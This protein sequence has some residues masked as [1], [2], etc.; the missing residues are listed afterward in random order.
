MDHHVKTPCKPHCD[1]SAYPLPPKD[2]RIGD[3]VGD[4]Y[5]AMMTARAA[6]T[7]KYE[8]DNDQQLADHNQYNTDNAEYA[9]QV[10]AGTLFNP[11]K[12]TCSTALANAYNSWN[13][14]YAKIVSA[15]DNLGAGDSKRQDGMNEQNP[16]LKIM[17]YNMAKDYYNVATSRCADAEIA[18]SNFLGYIATAENILY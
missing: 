16:M 2:D 7:A 8:P 4:A 10:A 1:L 13:T 6:A 3:A 9:A 14:A 11:N 17:K 5:D 15:W 12:T 18:H